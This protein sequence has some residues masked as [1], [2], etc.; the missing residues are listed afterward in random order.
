MRT[1]VGENHRVVRVAALSLL[2]IY[3]LII[4][5]LKQ[6]CQHVADAT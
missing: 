3:Q 4:V 1:L 5:Q 6:R 2:I